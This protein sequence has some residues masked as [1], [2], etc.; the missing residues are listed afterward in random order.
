MNN[1]NAL[2][3]GFVFWLIRFSVFFTNLKKRGDNM[4]VNAR[5]MSLCFLSNAHPTLR[6]VLAVNTVVVLSVRLSVLSRQIS[7]RFFKNSLSVPNG[8]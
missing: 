5:V 8:I 3:V 6:D 1:F 7:P 2:L 4:R